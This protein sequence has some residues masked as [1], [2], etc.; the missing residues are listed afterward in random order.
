MASTVTQNGGRKLIQLSPSEHPSRLK[1]RLGKVSKR[2]AESARVHIEA[3]VRS[4]KTGSGYPAATADWLAGLPQAMRRRLERVGLTAPQGRAECP[5]LAD[6][7][8][9]YVEGR[10]D[11]KEATATVYGHTRRNLLAFFG[12]EKRLDDITPGDADGFRVFLVTKEGLADN[13]VRRRMGPTPA[14]CSPPVRGCVSLP[15]RQR[16]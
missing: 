16:P 5:A 8:R 4:K 14:R 13:T 12:A 15:R 10:R 3:L 7:L 11:V 2:E 1:I 6:W 9:S